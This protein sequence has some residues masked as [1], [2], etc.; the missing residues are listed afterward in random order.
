MSILWRLL[1]YVRPYAGRLV[2]ASAMLILS[3]ALVGI[4]VSTVRPLVNEV[5]LGPTL[6]V[7]SV[8]R[9]PGPDILDS[10]RS[11]IPSDRISGWA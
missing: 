5:L 8:E 9:D 11:W 2:A 7:A 10:I 6:E 3:G 4:I 1:A